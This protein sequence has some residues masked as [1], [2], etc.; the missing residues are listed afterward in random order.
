MQMAA[1]ASWK[2]IFEQ[3]NLSESE[4]S[5]II[6]TQRET[7][8]NLRAELDKVKEIN[9]QLHVIIKKKDLEDKLALEEGEAK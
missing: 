4:F 8:V 9:R 6:K 5:E 2:G 3:L 7:I 1:E